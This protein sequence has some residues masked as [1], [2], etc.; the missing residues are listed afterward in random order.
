ML[1]QELTLSWRM[2]TAENT[3][4][5]TV[6]L[7]VVY[8]LLDHEGIM[9]CMRSRDGDYLDSL[10]SLLRS[11][12]ASR[13]LEP[14]NTLLA[15]ACLVKT[16]DEEW[17]PEWSDIGVEGEQ[18]VAWCLRLIYGAQVGTI[19]HYTVQCHGI[20]DAINHPASIAV[21]NQHLHV[22]SLFNICQTSNKVLYS[23]DQVDT[24]VK[25]IP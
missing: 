6:R 9:G 1:L 11:M 8:N 4:L 12:H 23:L 16:W 15:A 19:R 10:T 3:A 20:C 14:T 25:P 5:D 2:S 17:G 7:Q 18:K 24:T 13:E 21:S 22:V